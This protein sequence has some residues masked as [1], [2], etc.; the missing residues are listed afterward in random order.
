MAYKVPR[1]FKLFEELEEGQ[2]GGTPD[3]SVS[4]GLGTDKFGEEDN[5]LTKWN[6]CILGPPRVS[7]LF[8]VFHTIYQHSMVFF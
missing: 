2:K 3:G 6:G 5:T 4:W 8:S 7:K 1:R